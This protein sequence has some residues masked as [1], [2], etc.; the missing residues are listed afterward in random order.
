MGQGCICVVAST[1][2]LQECHG[3]RGR[4]PASSGGLGRLEK[5]RGAP[6]LSTELSVPQL[7]LPRAPRAALVPLPGVL[8]GRPAGLLAM[9]C[10]AGLGQDGTGWDGMEG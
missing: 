10:Y 7:E 8:A 6:D 2:S 5:L 3:L 9:L 4:V 1:L